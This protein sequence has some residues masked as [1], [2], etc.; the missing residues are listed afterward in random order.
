MKPLIIANWKLN[1]TLDEASLWLQEFDEIINPRF[2]QK[3][4]VVI[5]PS[6]V[7]IPFVRQITLINP[8]LRGLKLGAQTVSHFE[9]GAYTGETSAKQLRGIVDFCIV[10]HSER[11]K[12][13]GEINEQVIKKVEL[14]LKY[15]ITP[16]VCISSL[17]QA[18]IFIN[19]LTIQQFNNR[20]IFAYEPS[21]AIGSGESDT[22]EHAQKMALEIKRDLGQNTRVIYGGSVDAQNA[23]KFLAM[24][25]IFGLLV[26][27]ASLDAKKFAKIVNC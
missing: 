26:G 5:C 19:N 3:K 24:P 27:N 11:R 22:P 6:F 4:E 15:E 16:I 17:E 7:L 9:N 18:K 2:L 12:Y 13:F 10:G 1:K 25:D 20:L 23:G 8:D 21:F 14:C